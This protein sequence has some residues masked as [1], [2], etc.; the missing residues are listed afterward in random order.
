LPNVQPHYAVKSNNDTQLL[1]WIR[2]EGVRFDCASPIEIRQA[3]KT[4]APVS[5]IIYAN[6]CKSHEDINSAKQLGIS[7]TVVDSPEEVQKLLEAGFGS[8]GHR[9]SI[10]IRLKVP[11]A[12]SAIP[13]SRKFGAPIAWVPDILHAI[14]S[15]GTNIKHIGW[16]FH[17]GSLCGDP[18]QY[19]KAIEVCAE[20]AA[21]AGQHPEIVDIGGGFMPETFE[22]AAAEILPAQELFPMTTQWIAEPGRFISSPVATLYVKVIGAKRGHEGTKIYTVDDSVYGTFSNIPFDQQKPIYTLLASDASSRPHTTATLFGRTCDSADCLADSIDLPELRVGDI[23]E[24]KNMGAYTNV[25]ASCFN[26]FPMP[27]RSY[28]ITDMRNSEDITS[29]GIYKD[30]ITVCKRG[31]IPEVNTF[32]NTHILPYKEHIRS[33]FPDDSKIYLKLMGAAYMES[34]SHSQSIAEWFQQLAVKNHPIK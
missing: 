6:P 15:A 27:T 1:Q 30:F 4:G 26:G 24:V 11:D 34:R 12:A 29:W 23:L 19:R 7:T 9:G 25:S 32:H 14:R 16:S 8:D 5:H 18:K 22:A 20:A 21:I 33:E 2:Q 3:L 13:F 31:L 17:V 28:N 10:L